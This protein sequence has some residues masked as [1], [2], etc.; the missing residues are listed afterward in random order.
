M[1]IRDRCGKER[2]EAPLARARGARGRAQLQAAHHDRDARGLVR[3]DEV[4]EALEK[5]LTEAFSLRIPVQAVE[6]GA[7][8]RF[9]M[10]ARRWIRQGS[11]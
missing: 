4:A 7:L 9:E 3:R 5:S 8:P 6:L 10:K 2:G 11:E 1:C